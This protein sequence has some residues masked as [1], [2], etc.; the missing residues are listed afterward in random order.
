MTGAF[1]DPLAVERDH[2]PAV[3]GSRG[4]GFAS[5]QGARLRGLDGRDY[6]DCGAMI[7]VASIGHAH[8]AL[9]AALGAQAARLVACFGSFA[10]DRRSEL[11]AR[12]IALLPWARRVF[13]CNSGTEALEAALKLACAATGRV[14]LAH[15]EGSFHGR[16]LGSL[17]LC[18]RPA[19]RAP[20]ESMLARTRKI[21]CDDH[22]DLVAAIDENTAALVVETIQGEGGLRPLDPDWLRHAQ[23][24]CRERGALFIVDEVQTGVGRTGR[25]FDHESI[26]LVPDA[27]C[28]AKGLAGGL[29]IGCTLLGEA[30]GEP[31]SGIH[32]ST[33]GGNPLVAAAAL[34]TLD[35]IRAEDLVARAA[36]LGERAFATLR[37]GLDGRVRDIRGRGLMIGIETRGRVQD[38]LK[39]LQERGVIA[40]AAGPCVLRLLPPLVIDESD[41]DLALEAVVEVLRR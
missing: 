7:G 34:A 15:V 27:V 16:T 18:S 11:Y 41:W 38:A 20:F 3:Y 26:G 12:L 31:A 32:G 1:V 6:V 23:E 5:G 25:F 9:V 24:I 30:F 4:L 13:L 17:A 39:T 22:E 10:S 37:A 21:R 8:P 2:G 14:G 36:R 40:L 35:V 33:F 29:P 19:H 28:L